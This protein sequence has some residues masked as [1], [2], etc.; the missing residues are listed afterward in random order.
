MTKIE[1]IKTGKQLRKFRKALP[2]QDGKEKGQEKFAQIV[3][4]SMNRIN[5]IECKNLPVSDKLRKL[6]EANI[7][8]LKKK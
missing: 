1:D 2:K 6:I 4:Y 3:G 7:E 5:K 8:D